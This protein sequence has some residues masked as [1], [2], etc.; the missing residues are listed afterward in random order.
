MRER[1]SSETIG[2]GRIL[3]KRREREI[4]KET[5]YRFFAIRQIHFIERSGAPRS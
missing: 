3:F 2:M 1:I 5:V 4:G